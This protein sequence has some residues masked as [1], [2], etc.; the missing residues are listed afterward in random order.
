MARKMPNYTLP[1][2]EKTEIERLT[3]SYVDMIMAA[4]KFDEAMR[5]MSEAINKIY[6]IP[7]EYLRER[8]D[9]IEG[10]ARVISS[11]RDLQEGEPKLLGPG[12]TNS[13][14]LQDA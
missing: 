2:R 7:S 4:G 12:R 10:K 6:G 11:V 9:I 8:Q 1:Q 13:K 14:D 5:Q 3:D